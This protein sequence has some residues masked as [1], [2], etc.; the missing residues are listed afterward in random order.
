MRRY[1]LRAL[2]LLALLSSA[3]CGGNQNLVVLLPDA[4]GAVGRV[5]VST[6]KGSQVLDQAQQATKVTSAGKAPVKPYVVT[7]KEVD[8]VFGRALAAQPE[9][10]VKFLLYFK[11]DSTDLVEESRQLLPRIFDTIKRRRSMD[12]SVVGHSDTFGNKDYNLRL[13]R[14]RAEAVSQLL[15]EAGVDRDSLEITSHGEENPLV[16]TGDN[17][18]EPKN[19]RVEV[20]VR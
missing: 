10:P 3:G 5:E 2:C 9:P 20:T 17:V 7:Q 14:R 16:P 15:F 8:R 13:S 12:T 6:P 11:S 18:R 4:D 19:R 1:W